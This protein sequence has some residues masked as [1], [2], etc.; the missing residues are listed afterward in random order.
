MAASCPEFG[1]PHA[2]M[3]RGGRGLPKDSPR[4]AMRDPYMPPLKQLNGRFRGGLPV[5][6]AARSRLLSP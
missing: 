6:W 1:Y 3:A 2:R 4:P 5:A